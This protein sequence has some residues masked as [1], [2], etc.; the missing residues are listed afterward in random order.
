MNKNPGRPRP[1]VGVSGVVMQHEWHPGGESVR[2]PQQIFVEAYAQK[3][4]L[5]DAGRVLAL[6]VKVT[7]LTQ[8][9]DKDSKHG[10]DW[11][12]VGESEFA[13]ALGPKEKH[14]NTLGVAQ[15]YLSQRHIE[16]SAYRDEFMDRVVRRGHAWL[17]AVQF[18]MLP[19]HDRGETVDF[20]ENVRDTMP[21]TKIILACHGRAMRELGLKKAVRRL[22]SFAPYIDYVLFDAS[23]GKGIPMNVEQMDMYLEHTHESSALTSVGFAVAGGLDMERVKDDMPRLLAKYPDL[24]WD[25][26]AQLHPLNNIGRRPLQMDRVK[27]Y[28]EASVECLRA[29]R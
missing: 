1:Y 15:V 26:E 17:Q 5:Y 9:Q 20:V 3:A 27:Q 13:E 22:G 7:H 18:D 16:N 19:W 24:S 4:G 11:Y 21:D 14:P 28:L 29:V 6:G 8:F 12:P 25:A 23:H 10:R 2:L